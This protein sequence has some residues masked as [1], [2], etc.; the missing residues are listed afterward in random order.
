MS[1]IVPLIRRCYLAVSVADIPLLSR[2]YFAVFWRSEILEKHAV[3]MTY[4]L[5]LKPFFRCGTAKWPIAA[6]YNRL[7]AIGA[8]LR[9]IRR[10]L[11]HLVAGEVFEHLHQ[12]GVV[13]AFAAKRGRG[14]ERLLGRR[15]VGQR[16]VEGP[17]ARQ[18]QAQILRPADGSQTTAANGTAGQ[19]ESGIWL[20]KA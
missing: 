13:P 9:K 16:Q 18:C 17:R 5:F 7:A 12:A 6:V 4:D 11:G 3:A 19:R 8:W 1:L 10:P 14:V 20:A 15:G 2:C